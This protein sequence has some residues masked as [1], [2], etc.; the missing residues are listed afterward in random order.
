MEDGE[1]FWGP[2]IVVN[3][4]RPDWLKGRVLCDLLTASGW[5]YT[6]EREVH[7]C[8]VEQWAWKHGDG[9]PCIIAIRFPADH[10][11]YQVAA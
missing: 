1:N 8:P 7:E 10:A 5:R 9:R 11:I 2:E 4:E 6:G 3:G